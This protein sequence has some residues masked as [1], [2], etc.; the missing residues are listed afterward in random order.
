MSEISRMKGLYNLS[1]IRINRQTFI[2][3]FKLVKSNYKEKRFYIWMTK[4]FDI[5]LVMHE[6]C[7]SM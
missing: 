2:E 7:G 5:S 1:P 6:N 3:I 4:E